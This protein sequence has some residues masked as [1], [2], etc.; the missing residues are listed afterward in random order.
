[1]GENL[2]YL[3]PDTLGST[4]CTPSLPCVWG[5]EVETEYLE[6]DYLYMLIGIRFTF[7]LL[8][9]QI[10]LSRHTRQ[11]WSETTRAW[12]WISYALCPQQLAGSSWTYVLPIPAAGLQEHLL[13]KKLN[14]RGTFLSKLDSSVSFSQTHG[15]IQR[16]RA[17]TK[18]K[19]SFQGIL[20][21]RRKGSLDR[22][23]IL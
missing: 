2:I 21:E 10:L 14:S 18:V 13:A 22:S 1:M 7:I 9:S 8:R 5:S 4:V 12:N 17:W 23:M 6:Q 11:V 3:N 15:D 20:W 19:I 16:N